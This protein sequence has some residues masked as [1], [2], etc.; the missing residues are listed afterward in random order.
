MFRLTLAGPD[1]HV[2]SSV[3]VACPHAAAGC[4]VAPPRY[5]WADIARVVGHGGRDWLLTQIAEKRLVPF[6]HGL[7]TRRVKGRVSRERGSP[8]IAKCVFHE[9]GVGCTIP[10]THRP[11]TCN[12]YVCRDVFDAAAREG[13]GRAARSAE[14]AHDALVAS[15]IRWDEELATYVRETYPEGT[16]LDEAFFDALGLVFEQM[17]RD[18]RGQEASAE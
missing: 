1:T 10:A 15:F 6:E 8:R 2:A 4:C 11:A 9:G 5:A 14:N 3:C 17:R 18:A 12:Y 16:V 13:E 7:I